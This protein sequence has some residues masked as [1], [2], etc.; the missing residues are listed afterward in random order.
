MDTIERIQ[1]YTSAGM[2]DH[3]PHA[4]RRAP[5]GSITF[6]VGNNTYVGSPSPQ[7]SPVND[8]V[9]DKAKSPNW[10]NLKE[11]QFLPQYNDP[12]FGNSTRTGVHA[13]VWRLEPGNQVLAAVQRHAEPVR[14]RL[15]PQWRSVHVRQRHGMGR[16]LAVVPRKPDHPHDSR[17]RRRLPE[18]HRQVSGRVL[19]HDSG[20]AAHA[21]RVAG[22]RR[23]VSELRVSLLV[24]RQPVRSRLVARSPPLYVAD[25]GG[26]HLPR[27]RGSRGVR[28]R[29]ADADH[30]PR[31]RAG[32]QHLLH[33]R[34]QSGHWRPLQSDLDGREA[35][36]ARH[37][38]HPRRRPPAAAAV[39]LGMGGD[40][41]RQDG[42]GR[43]GV[44][45]GAGAAGAEHDGGRHGS[46]PRDLRAAAARIAAECRFPQGA[47]HGSRRERAR[48]GRLCG[49]HPHDRWREGGRGRGAEGQRALCSAPRR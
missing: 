20:A 14:L 16:E 9:V 19:R 15:Q 42:D 41:K 47:G 1:R 22:R 46:R 36:A 25:P 38:R 34:W 6:L 40:R 7:G 27:P 31:G 49:R 24:L 4:I 5:D 35:G 8:D 2:G 45:H 26:R 23:D 44:R 3:G 11:R 12:R 10:N 32:R 29:R 28:P 33:D 17:R 39:E 30:R 48:R 37:D 13:T 21:S 18:R 43:D